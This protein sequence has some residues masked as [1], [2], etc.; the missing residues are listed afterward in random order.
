MEL[1]LVFGLKMLTSFGGQNVRYMVFSF[2]L[3]VYSI[4]I[5]LWT[6]R[7]LF[8]FFNVTEPQL[9]GL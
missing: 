6:R 7:P 2:F 8:V 9:G 4:D 3:V 5:P 1:Y